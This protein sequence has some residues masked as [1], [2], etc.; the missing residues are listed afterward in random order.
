MAWLGR[1]RMQQ[2]GGLI[3]NPKSFTQLRAANGRRTRCSLFS[4]LTNIFLSSC[5]PGLQIVGSSESGRPDTLRCSRPRPLANESAITTVQNTGTS[6]WCRT[7][8]SQAQQ[9]LY[10]RSYWAIAIHLDR[11]IHAHAWSCRA[12]DGE[13]CRQHA[14]SLGAQ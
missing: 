10:R 14:A 3:N 7:C 1:R 2:H 8:Q 4:S 9:Q 11:Y 6:T 13:P 5:L 12:L